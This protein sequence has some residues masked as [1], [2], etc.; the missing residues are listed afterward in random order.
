MVEE[1]YFIA[2]N[3]QRLVSPYIQQWGRAPSIAVMDSACKIFYTADIDGIIGY[4]DEAGCILVFGDP[5]CKPDDV[6]RL[7]EAFHKHF[8][9]QK[10]T[11]IYLLASEHFK[12]WASKHGYIKTALSMGNEIIVNPLV[13]PLSLRGKHASSLRNIYSL[14][15]RVGIT[16]HEYIGHD[17][18]IEHTMEE[19]GQQW[20]QNRKGPQTS[21][22]H[23][24]IFSNRANKRFFYAEHNK[25]IVG[26]IILNRLDAYQGW[27]INTLV[28]SNDAPKYSSEYMILHTL[29]LLRKERCT[30]FSFGT[31]PVS[32]LKTIE[33]LGKVATLLAPYFFRATKKI[34]NL[35]KRKQYWQKFAPE[36][37]P[38]YLLIHKKGVGVRDIFGILR[39]FNV[40]I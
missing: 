13:D 36:I 22:L 12:A 39:A 26:V 40:K 9:A 24:D 32:D 21:L 4:R 14:I 34:F 15:N 17:M 7:V 20:V 8:I 19:I 33:G 28:C 6:S 2:H 23:V 18:H 30:Y 5:L 11:I 35:N 38:S 3:E 1:K 37:H 10:K 27:T 31:L 16:F 29:S 25:R